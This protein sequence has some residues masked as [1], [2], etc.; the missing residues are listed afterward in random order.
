MEEIVVVGCGVIGL[1][2]A[3]RL[4]EAGYR[5]KIVARDLPPATTSNRA[6]AIWLPYR[7]EPADKVARWS[8][9]SYRRYLREADSPATG[10]TMV[11]LHLVS[12]E[13]MAEP[14]WSR[15]EYALRRLDPEEVPGGRRD[16]FVVRVPFIHSEVYLAHLVAIFEASGGC[17]ERRELGSLE[18]LEGKARLVVHCTG[19]GARELVGDASMFAI[20]GQLAVV[21]PQRPVRYVSDEMSY[22]DPVYV[23]PRGD[24]CVLGGTAVFDREDLE[25][26]TATREVLLERCL[27]LEPGLEGSR[28]LRSVVGLR[29]GRPAVRLEVE[30]R[31]T[32]RVI[33]N[34]G[35]GGS[36]FTVAW[37]CA[38]EVAALTRTHVPL[39][40]RADP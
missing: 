12:P 39:R 24:E 17:I 22:S 19:L 2:T 6:A 9:L 26:D 15:P 21:R 7:A 25:E 8:E 20:R 37:G 23:L 32:S 13:S 16:G 30:Q 35:H 5:V 33:H 28:F 1:S 36:G 40:R 31:G 34:Y 4:Q 38:D 27:R 10:V 3:V 29:P 14:Y 18:E 11:D